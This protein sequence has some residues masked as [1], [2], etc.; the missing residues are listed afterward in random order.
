M[1]DSAEGIVSVFGLLMHSSGQYIDS[2]ISLQAKDQSPQSIGSAITYARRYQLTS[3]LG[4]AP[5]ADDDDGQA[6]Q[7]KNSG[8]TAEKTH[9]KPTPAK[10]AEVPPEQPADPKTGEIT[11]PMPAD[12]Q[13]LTCS[14]ALALKAGAVYNV[15]GVLTKEP[16]FMAKS[17]TNKSDKTWYQ[18]A[19]VDIDGDV[20]GK[21][22]DFSAFGSPA[23][24]IKT[25]DAI[26]ITGMEIKEF[27]GTVFIPK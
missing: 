2:K 4:I 22:L 27:G 15:F 21:P 6:A 24:M 3:M 26:R 14:A 11:E 7:D 23:E 1:P 25:G 16:K 10:T 17:A 19:E 9:S 13:A 5:A 8:N 18:I 12:A 20:V